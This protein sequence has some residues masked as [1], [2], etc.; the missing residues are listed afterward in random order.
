MVAIGHCNSIM[1]GYAK[2]G[3][4]QDARQLFDELSERTVVDWNLMISGYWN[5]RNARR[6]F[7][8]IPKRNVITWNA[9]VAGCL[10]VKDLES[11]RRCFNF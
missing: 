10:K 7:D 11:V 8:M 4:V 9:M 5:C 1:D 2:Y 3:P 6:M